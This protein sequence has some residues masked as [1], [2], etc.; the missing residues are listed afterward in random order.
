M[1]TVTLEHRLTVDPPGSQHLSALQ[2]ILLLWKKTQDN[3]ASM[4]INL[5]PR[6]RGCGETLETHDMWNDEESFAA[7]PHLESLRGRK[8]VRMSPRLKL[9][10]PTPPSIHSLARLISHSP[11]LS[12]KSLR[13]GHRSDALRAILD[14]DAPMSRLL[15]EGLFMQ[16]CSRGRGRPHPPNISLPATPS[17]FAPPPP[18]RQESNPSEQPRIEEALRALLQQR[19]DHSRRGEDETGGGGDPVVPFRFSSSNSAQQQQLLQRPRGGV[20]RLR[21]PCGPPQ[22]DTMAPSLPSFL[23][24]NPRF[25][26]GP[27]Q[28]M[29][30]LRRLVASN[31]SSPVQPPP[32]V[33][34][35]R[36]PAP[37]AP[38][39]IP[40]PPPPSRPP[41][42]GQ[43][44]PPPSSSSYSFAAGGASES[45]SPFSVISPQGTRWRRVGR[46]A[47]RNHASHRGQHAGDSTDP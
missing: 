17:S 10:T 3:V 19:A 44:P 36:P 35:S 21:W 32:P 45:S 6:L 47:V 9:R 37:V 16:P 7:M 31:A 12:V 15:L 20:E 26:E 40:P 23:L 33:C 28:H 29:C 34:N 13:P 43:R 30:F 25:G 22:P 4:Q 18:E 42:R 2:R 11:S 8:L 46:S 38:P 39:Q 41:L 27:P 1:K 5:S 24:G 14:E